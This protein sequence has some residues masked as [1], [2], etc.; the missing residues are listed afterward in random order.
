MFAEGE[1]DL[2]K[3]LGGTAYDIDEEM[4]SPSNLDDECEKINMGVGKTPTV[5]AVWS[6]KYHNS[7]TF[8]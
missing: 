6:P 7:V 2:D 5:D 8:H 1:D 4:E 3:I